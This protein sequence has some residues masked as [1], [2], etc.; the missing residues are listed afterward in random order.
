M[1]HVTRTR[2]YILAGKCYHKSD[3]DREANEV[4]TIDFSE[5]KLWSRLWNR[6]LAAFT[7][8]RPKQHRYMRIDGWRVRLVSREEVQKSLDKLT[9]L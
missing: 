4:A 2:R 5:P 1:T 7:S 6:V 8:S 9:Y 3:I